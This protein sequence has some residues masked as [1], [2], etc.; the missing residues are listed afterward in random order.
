MIGGISIPENTVDFYHPLIYWIT[1]YSAAPAEQTR[2]IVKFEYF[3][4]SSSVVILNIFRMLSDLK[5]SVQID[6]FYESDDSEMQELG[7]DYKR[8]LSKDLSF[9][10]IP[11]DSF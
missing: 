9:N 3:N 7:E 10:L 2:F 5:S 6:W 11:I 4:T 8:M 1:Q